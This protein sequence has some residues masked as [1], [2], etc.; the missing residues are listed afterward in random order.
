MGKYEGERA[1]ERPGGMTIGNAIQVALHGMTDGALKTHPGFG[2][3]IL[4]EGMYRCVNAVMAQGASG[5]DAKAKATERY[6]RFASFL[7]SPIERNMAAAL[8]TANWSDFGID[9]PQ[10]HFAAKDGDNFVPTGPV[11]LIPQLAFAR[12][13]IDIAVFIRSDDD[14]HRIVAIECDGKAYHQDV[15]ADRARDG[16]Y[17]SW[18]IPTIRFTGT[19]LRNSPIECA[20]S[21]VSQLI[22]WG[23]AK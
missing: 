13:R 19:D 12:N 15:N 5:D 2:S 21:V 3:T 16:Y 6:N 4:G 1:Q 10:V 7:E 18:G 22:A 11:T 8:L 20:D 9:V 14:W 23:C 17:A